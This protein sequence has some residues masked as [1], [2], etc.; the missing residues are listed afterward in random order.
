M[1]RVFQAEEMTRAKSGRQDFY[2]LES[3]TRLVW[4][5]QT[6]WGEWRRGEAA[7]QGKGGPSRE[8]G[9]QCRSPVEKI[10]L[11]FGIFST[12]HS[13]TQNFSLFC[14]TSRDMENKT[15]KTAGRVTWDF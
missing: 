9:S 5:E 1:R 14:Y 12:I 15:K 4:L 7:R 8:M 13:S 3:A 10:S 11:L 2:T 6:E